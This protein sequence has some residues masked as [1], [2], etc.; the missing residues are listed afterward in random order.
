MQKGALAKGKNPMVVRPGKHSLDGQTLRNAAESWQKNRETSLDPA[1]AKRVWSRLERDVLPSLG[2]MLLQDITPP[3]VL[4]VIRKI[5]DRGALDISRL[6][7]Q[8][9][10][11]IF[12]FSIASGICTS[13]PTAH[14][15]GAL[16]P[17]PR[18]K[19]MAKL[20][21]SELP[22]PVSKINGYF[23]GGHASG[24]VCT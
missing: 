3:D 11:Q 22:E 8:S 16:K 6:A 14:L 18:V 23:K 10:S 20:P 4:R 21:L 13:F 1:H 7:K 17:R 9:I 2:D 19:H 24:R 5:E 12:Q 15:H